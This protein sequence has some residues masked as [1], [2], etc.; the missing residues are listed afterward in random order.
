MKLRTKSIYFLSLLALMNS[1][2]AS[3]NVAKGALPSGKVYLGLFGGGGSLAND[4]DTEQY[5]TVLLPE[6]LGGALA[7]NAFGE[8]DNDSASF[9][10]LQLGYQ[11]QEIWLGAGSQLSLIPAVELEG[12]YMYKRSYNGTLSNNTDRLLEHEFDVTYPMK[13]S[14]FLTNIVLSFNH[15][16]F[17]VS[18]YIGLGIGSAIVDITGANSKQ[19]DPLETGTNHYNTNTDDTDTTFAGQVKLGI[20]YNITQA[21]SVFAEYRWLYLS[22]TDFTFGSTDYSTHSATTSWQV[23]LDPQKY[24]LG[25]LGIRISL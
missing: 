13:K 17:P 8:V 19:M 16:R 15:P 21:I 2:F 25:S 20:S 18:P 24:N 9:I 3:Q 1:S 11:A 6:D 23:D 10:G 4:F 14:I 12:Y 7:V 22:N 5:G